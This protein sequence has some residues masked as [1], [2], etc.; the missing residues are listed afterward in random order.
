MANLPKYGTVVSAE[1]DGEGNRPRIQVA[2]GCMPLVV[3]SSCTRPSKPFSFPVV[4]L[5]LCVF[6]LCFHRILPFEP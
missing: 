4:R 5:C 3:G 2:F 1:D 6:G